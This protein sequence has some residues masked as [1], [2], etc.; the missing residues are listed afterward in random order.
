MEYTRTYS[1]MKW[2][3]LYISDPGLT[4]HVPLVIFDHSV[5]DVLGLPNK[6][7]VERYYSDFDQ[8]GVNL[9]SESL[10]RDKP[11]R[12]QIG[13]WFWLLNKAS[14]ERLL[15]AWDSFFVL[16]RAPQ[17]HGPL[18]KQIIIIGGKLSFALIHCII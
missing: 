18:F 6:L 10:L 7:F 2:L 3:E 4:M 13:R 17:I 15:H 12:V 1:L 5:H 16:H 8:T 11:I 9:L 14:C